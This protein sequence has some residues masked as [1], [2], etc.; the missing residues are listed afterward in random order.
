VYALGKTTSTAWVS[1]AVLY[2]LLLQINDVL[3]RDRRSLGRWGI[4][5]L[6]AL[7]GGTIPVAVAQIESRF[8]D[9]E[10]FVALQAVTLAAFWLLLLMA[11]G[12]L[13]RIEPVQMR[14]GIHFNRRR[15]GASLI[16]L[17]FVGLAAMIDRYQ[18]SFFPSE[19]P[20]YVGIST[21]TPFL[22]S[23]ITSSPQIFDGRDVFRRLLARVET[24]PQKN[25]PEYGMLALATGDR[26]W[27]QAFRES[28]LD[29]ASQ[30]LFTGPAN[31]VKSVQHKAA[32]RAYYYSLVRTTF[33]GVFTS[34]EEEKLRQWFVSINRRA[35]AAEWVDWM[36]ALAFA[37][38]PEGPYEN[39]ETGAGLLALLE[40]KGLAA[41]DLSSTNLDYLQRNRRGWLA[42]FRNTDDALIYQPEWIDNAFFQSP[43]TGADSR[44]N[45]QLSFEWLLLQAL[46]DGQ[47]ARYNH[48]SLVSL[49]GI[50]YLGARLLDD[51]R[52]VWLSGKA[53]TSFESREQHL[54]AQPGVEGPVDRLGYSPTQGSCLLYGNSGLPNQIGPLAPDKIVLRDGWSDDA[55][56]LLLNLRFTGWHRYKGTNTITLLYQHGPL[57]SEQVEGK[58]FT[59]L[60][61]GRSLFR[62]KR[63]PRENLNGF[64]LERTGMS[65]AVHWL[66]GVGGPWA[67]DPPYYAR[68]ERFET[69]PRV[70]VSSTVL[71]GWRGWRHR[72]TV[73]FYHGG[74]IVILDNAEGATRA[75]AAMIWH[76]AGDGQI[77]EGRLR[78]RGGERPAEMVLLPVG[79]GAIRVERLSNSDNPELQLLYQSPAGGRL[80]L[81]TLF[82]TKEWVG[83]GTNITQEAQGTVLQIVKENKHLTVPLW[84]AEVR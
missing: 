60:P 20:P 29:E 27:A 42:R 65:A 17:A 14:R 53:L 25:A 10:F 6:L 39:Q 71:E 80:D 41:S 8:S 84:Q 5:G 31:S 76:V 45:V 34:R 13:W 3:A 43:Y 50:A 70:D 59:W 32:L 61:V 38:W 16:F 52:Y 73:Y 58:P 11:R 79:N 9:E 56:Y 81:V 74:P 69:G 78:L 37:K 18:N 7:A 36:Y 22:C 77:H 49:A 21:T 28:L 64:L 66:T 15:M 1:L 44:Q 68:V 83:A 12:L 63:I 26:D 2:V 23:E 67:Q 75:P 47:S 33:P 51:P 4:H 54:L 30:N 40:S 48:P 62:D 55:A 24:N 46:P 57:L 19:A 82:L 35:L 72:R